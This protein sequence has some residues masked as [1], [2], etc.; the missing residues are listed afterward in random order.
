[1]E[2]QLM[3]ILAS[4]VLALVYGVVSIGWI[5]KKPAGNARMQEI[6][7][8]VQQGAQAYLNRQY[9][10]IAM[11]GAV[12]FVALWLAL[13]SAD[14]DRL[15]DRRGAVGRGGLHR[16]ER[17]GARQRPHRR[18]RFARPQCGAQRRVQGRRHHRHAGG[19]AGPAGRGRLLRRADHDGRDV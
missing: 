8:A 7:L 6:A 10:T 12:L 2:T 17:L 13:G 11:V 3:W 4:A 18:S 15:P 5:L 9:T 16:H 14:R 19:R 1:M